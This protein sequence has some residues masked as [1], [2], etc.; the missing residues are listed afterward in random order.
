MAFLRAL[1][2]LRESLKMSDLG[3][4]FEKLQ[5]ISPNGSSN[6]LHEQD[7]LNL[8]PI[9]FQEPSK[10]FSWFVSPPRSR[11]R[12]LPRSVAPSLTPSLV[13]P[14]ARS[15][16]PIARSFAPSL[17]RLLACL[18]HLDDHPARQRYAPLSHFS[19]SQGD[20]GWCSDVTST[21]GVWR[22]TGVR[23]RVGAR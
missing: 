11:P 5:K 8:A 20:S 1:I 23:F 15:F 22:H 6:H 21:H 7:D 2:S 14:F 12:S 19:P 17:V 9:C 13:R 18:A 3:H 4:I 16:A 10:S